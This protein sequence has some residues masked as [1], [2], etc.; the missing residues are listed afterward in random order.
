L[1]ALSSAPNVAFDTHEALGAV[2]DH[3][4][5]RNAFPKTY[6]R[7]RI[8]LRPSETV[9]VFSPIKVGV[10]LSG[11]Q[12]PGGHHVIAG[13]YDYIKKSSPLS[14]MV[15]F[16][17]GPQGI[18]NGEYCVVDDAMMNNYRNTGGFDMI[19]SGRHKIE[20]PEQFAAS[21]ANCIELDLDGLIVI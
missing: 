12:A 8:S 10:V 16:L 4:D 2:A 9:G 17:D 3:D 13:I 19:C 7:A 6:G 20:K 11:G 15:G 14:G 1:Q 18:Y 5:I 21:M